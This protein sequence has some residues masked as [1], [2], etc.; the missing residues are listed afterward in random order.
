MPS[1]MSADLIRTIA[2]LSQAVPATPGGG[3]EVAL[4][5]ATRAL[6]RSMQKEGRLAESPMQLALTR[7]VELHHAAAEQRLRGK[8]VL[9]TGGS[10]CVGS[11]LRQLLAGFGPAT[12]INLDIAP[13]EG[14][15][16]WLQADI[17]DAAMLDAAFRAA[18][19]EVVFHLASIREPGKAELVVQEAVD[20][21]VFGTA[22]VIAACR[23]HGVGHAVYSS[24]GKCYAY[25]TDHVYTASKK[26]AELQW[27]AAAREG[28][29]TSFAMTRFTHVLENGIVSRDIAAGIAQGMVGLHGP[30]RHFNIQNLRQATHL[31]VNALALAGTQAPDSFWSAVDLGWPVNTLELA[32]FEIVRSGRDVGVR[33][34]GIPKGY[35]ES[36]FRG[37][38][39]WSGACDYHPLVNALEAPTVVND[40]TG[41]M[42]GAR[43]APCPE[44]ALQ[45]ALDR[46]HTRLRSA[47]TD[48]ALKEALLQSVSGVTEAV[49]RGVSPGHLLD[50]LWWGAAPGWIEAG[51]T[52]FRPIMTML[53]DLLLPLLSQPGLHWD[54]SAHGKL[55]DIAA[56]FA[57]IPGLGSR[58]ERFQAVT[59]PLCAA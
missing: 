27:M 6:I 22:N 19:P 56:T 50:I 49:F 42:I 12:L 18:R 40:S 20:T 5:R 26:L 13:H 7:T 10:G 32:L 30:D 25:L 24:T 4:R 43:I 14:E 41:T 23:R 36:F 54:S 38:F 37:Q 2:E 59:Q 8:R 45:Q 57:G 29:E 51:T 55:Q 31:L 44:A 34:L 46:L 17:R 53:A 15:G 48:A 3:A 58:A 39:D 1:P 16:R 9:V 33:F 52:R 35:D 28:G 47:E 11:R 21:N